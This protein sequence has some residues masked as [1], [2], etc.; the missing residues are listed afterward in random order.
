MVP[1]ST[2]YRKHLFLLQRMVMGTLHQE[3][4]LGGFANTFLVDHNLCISVIS[5]LMVVGPVSCNNVNVALCFT[6]LMLLPC[7]Y[8]GAYHSDIEIL[9]MKLLM[10]NKRNL[11]KFS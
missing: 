11:L 2:V 4:Y 8:I 7:L 5:S 3:I 6:C 9:M 10:M 1:S